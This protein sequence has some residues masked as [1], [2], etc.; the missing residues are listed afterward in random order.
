MLIS[1][2]VSTYNRPE[3][4]SLILNAFNYQTDKDFELIIADDG[5]KAEYQQSISQMMKCCNYPITHVYQEDLGFRLA[6]IRNLAASKAKGEYLIFLD[7]DC[8]PRKSF[9]AN[10]RKLLQKGFLVAGN[11]ICLS[12]KFT[13]YVIE[14]KEPIWNY[15]VF[16]W[17]GAYFSRSIFRLH[18][19]INL[20]YFQKLR[21]LKD[22][23][24]KARGCNFALHKDEFF[25]VD[26]CDSAFEGW[27]YEDSDLAIRLIH[28]G[29]KIKS[30]RFATGVFHLYHYENDRSHQ[31]E[32]YK[33]LCDRLNSDIIKAKSGISKIDEC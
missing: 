28:N 10:H 14:K 29:T 5:T 4:L 30:G 3:A 27:G 26:G 2:I 22:N 24:K 18:P 15:S 20:P 16:K 11:R 25:A 12:E 21:N 32:N 17:F 8:I 19:L 31:D 1:V 7:G 23:W 13:N 9:I 33:L 6:R